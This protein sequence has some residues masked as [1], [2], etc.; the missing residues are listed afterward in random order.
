[1]SK[2]FDE[3]YRDQLKDVFLE[4]ARANIEQGGDALVCADVYAEQGKPD[5]ALAYLLL[6]DASEEVKR[7]VLAHSYE[8]RATISEEKAEAFDL[9]FHRPFP[10]IKVEAQ[11]DRM[12]AQ[13]VR[14][15]QRIRKSGKSL[16]VN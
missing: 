4:K 1:M 11:K 14:R 7:D 13:Q 10:L 2:R 3:L 5:F 16:N 9:Q 15:G 8:R 6:T 12:V